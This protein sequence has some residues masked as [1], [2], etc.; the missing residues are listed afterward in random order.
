LLVP[1]LSPPEADHAAQ[2]PDVFASLQSGAGSASTFVVQRQV[3]S[4]LAASAN[5]G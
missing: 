5:D 1:S 4:C 3:L 2:G